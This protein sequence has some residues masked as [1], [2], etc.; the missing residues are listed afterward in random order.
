MDMPTSDFYSSRSNYETR[1]QLIMKEMDS[2]N[3]AL[4]HNLARNET[5]ATGFAIDVFLQALIQL[6]FSVNYTFCCINSSTGQILDFDIILQN[7]L[8]DICGGYYNLG[9]TSR[10][11]GFLAT[12]FRIRDCSGS[13][14][15]ETICP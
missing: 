9:T 1:L 10:L 13:E 5:Q 14:K 6:P 15:Q 11:Y 4:D 3:N 8:K 7:K 2:G 12:I